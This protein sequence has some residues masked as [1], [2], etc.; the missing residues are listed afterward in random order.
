MMVCKRQFLL[1]AAIALWSV[2]ANAQDDRSAP[3]LEQRLSDPVYLAWI[4]HEDVKGCVQCHFRGPSDEELI[5]GSFVDFARRIEM[6]RWLSQDKHTIARRRVEPFSDEQSEA[7]LDALIRRVNKQQE[8]AIAALQ[9]RNRRVDVSQ[10]GFAKVPEEWIGPSNILSRRICD[11]LWGSGSVKT[12]AGYSKFRDQCLTCHGGYRPGDR[13]FD[14]ATIDDSQLGID[15]LYCHQVGENQKWIDDHSSQNAAKNWRLQ[16]PEQKANAGMRDLVN[17]SNQSQMCFDCHIGNREKNMFVT[18]EMYAAG[19]PPIPSIE[20]QTF[21]NE[22]PQHWQSQSQL[23]KSL[24][25][26]QGRSEYFRVNYPG[27][28]TTQ[29]YSGTFWNTRALM[30]AA[31]AAR[32][33]WLDLYIASAESHQWADYSLYD[34]A[35]CH[36]ELR[37]HSRRQQRY[38]TIDPLRQPSAPGRPRQNEWP[39]VVLR[40]AYVFGGKASLTKTL[41]LETKL[42]SLFNA[43]PFGNAD[44]VRMTAEELRSHLIEAID[45]VERKPVP[46]SVAKAVLRGLSTTPEDKLLTYDSA[47]QVVWAIQMVAKELRDEAASLDADTEAI[48]AKLGDAE[49]TGIE[50]K[51]PAGRQQFIYPDELA[52]DLERRSAFEPSRLKRQLNELHQRLVAAVQP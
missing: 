15:C 40:I 18:H 27:V 1:L 23:W 46:A 33:Q 4:A 21:C 8:T 29:D 39:D 38:L 9:K 48:I 12:E 35:A 31:L 24:S 19:H 50:S 32:V 51:L 5:G 41:E 22:M 42:E 30:V 28:S 52:S 37:S 43:T 16:S 34:C 10:I 2:S 26:Y 45:T 7:E 13:G 14:L 11:K 17:T 6:D 25:N 3:T 47:R 20:L 44:D 49:L 36:H